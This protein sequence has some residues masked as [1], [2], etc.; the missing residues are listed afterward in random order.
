[1]C[2]CVRIQDH[3]TCKEDEA[4]KTSL[5]TTVK[6]P[7]LAVE[8]VEEVAPLSM[9]ISSS[10]GGSSVLEVE[11]IPEKRWSVR[12]NMKKA[13]ASEISERS[14]SSSSSSSRVVPVGR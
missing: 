3:G 12:Y 9:E 14:R 5:N 8:V 10:V 1:M 6:V 13:R 7:P 4:K 2:R 11:S